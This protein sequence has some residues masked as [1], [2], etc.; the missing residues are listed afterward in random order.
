M[1]CG[2]RRGTACLCG[3]SVRRSRMCSA[4]AQQCTVLRQAT[5]CLRLA[6]A[7]SVWQASETPV[8]WRSHACKDRMGPCPSMEDVQFLPADKP[9]WSGLPIG[10]DSAAAAQAATG[11][12]AAFGHQ[13][14][15]AALVETVQC[16][17]KMQLRSAS[18]T[19]CPRGK[20][21]PLLARQRLRLPRA[22]VCAVQL[23][24]AWPEQ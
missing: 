15:P 21:R 2:P 23:A 24:I 3:G 13:L 1:A 12:H 10:F 19:V 20:L 5:Q 22:Q 9:V 16:Q 11:T 14:G 7:A 8:T 6:A 4:V 17:H 18:A